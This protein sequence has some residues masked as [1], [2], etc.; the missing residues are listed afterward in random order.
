MA[1][2]RRQRRPPAAF[3]VTSLLTMGLGALAVLASMIWLALAYNHSGLLA[4]LLPVLPVLFS[5]FIEQCRNTLEVY[6]E[7]EDEDE[8]T[9]EEPSQT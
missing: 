7:D 6:R 2:P 4:V 1:K 8:E 5:F 3:S 9:D